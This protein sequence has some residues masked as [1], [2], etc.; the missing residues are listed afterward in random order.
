MENI[1]KILFAVGA[2][3]LW[4]FSRMRKK[5]NKKKI[6]EHTTTNQNI[7]TSQDKEQPEDILSQWEKE[8]SLEEIPVQEEKQESTISI[9]KTKTEEK[10]TESSKDEQIQE[11]KD[12]KEKSK[13]ENKFPTILDKPL[14]PENVRYGIIFSEIMKRRGSDYNK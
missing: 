4:A 6:E 9:E 7:D 2:V 12:Q 13:K 5:E 8:L 3:L 11:K 10:K 14:S 1:V